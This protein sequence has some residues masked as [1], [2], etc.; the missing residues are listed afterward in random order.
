MGGRITA[1]AIVFV[2]ARLGLGGWVD[3]R[4]R[5]DILPVRSSWQG[6]ITWAP[7]NCN[8]LEVSIGILLFGFNR[9]QP[10]AIPPVH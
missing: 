4:A 10:V 8:F 5:G 7:W 9:L 2:F 6:N 1:L 3:A